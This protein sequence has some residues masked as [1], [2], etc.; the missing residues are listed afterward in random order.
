MQMAARVADEEQPPGEEAEVEWAEVRQ[1][2]EKVS[3]LMGQY[4]LKGYRMLSVNCGYCEVSPRD[5]RE[6]M[7]VMKLDKES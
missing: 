6:H 5:D 2:R 1:T 3:H 7:H 4:L